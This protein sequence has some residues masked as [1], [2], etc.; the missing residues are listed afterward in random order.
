MKAFSLGRRWHGAS[1]DGCGE[2]PHLSQLALPAPPQG[3]A[4][5]SLRSNRP[6]GR[7]NN[8]RGTTLV[9]S[10]EIPSRSNK[11][12]P[13]TRAYGRTYCAG[14]SAL[15]LGRDGYLDSITLARTTRQLSAKLRLSDRLR[16]S[17]FDVEEILAC[18]LPKVK[19]FSL[20]NKKFFPRSKKWLTNRFCYA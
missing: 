18:P 14:G 9:I 13:L 6:Q 11:R 12:Y 19:C 17:L 16:Q 8:I 10:K 7:I 5:K 20:Q 2:V 3:G 1:R 4:K 15:R